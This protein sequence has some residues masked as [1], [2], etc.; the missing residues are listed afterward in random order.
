MTGADGFIGSHLVESLL[1]RGESVTAL[2]WYNSFGHIGWL[3]QIPR[4]LRSRL[5]IVAGDIRD[6][7]QLGTLVAGS[8][9]IIH[10]A[11][12]VGIPY[13][14]QAAD[15]YIQTNVTGTLN[16]LQAAQQTGAARVVIVSTSEVYGSAQQLPIAENHPRVGQSPYAASKIAAEE[17]AFSFYRSYHLP[18]TIVRPFNTYGPRQSSRA[19]IPT[20]I[21]QI[22]AGQT[23]LQLGS[24]TPQRD[25]LYV[26]ET[27]DGLIAAAQAD[28]SG[29]GQVIN[30]GTGTSYSVS[31]LVSI[32]SEIAGVQ[33][34]VSTDAT[35]VRPAASEVDHL[36]A[37]AT[38]AETLLGWKASIPL[39]DG[40][41][42]TIDWFRTSSTLTIRPRTDYQI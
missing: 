33:I 21:T 17:L 37:D 5:T 40:L 4:D 20:I 35:R 28:E 31:E 30:L 41:R 29:I 15:S 7:H 3:D 34:A 25:L 6:R 12:L 27:A 9:H 8:T 26:K 36:L 22:L 13:S 11:A 39:R 24:L 32:I 14:Y 2:V 42:A 38:K 1:A 16:L 19:I 18:V 23:Q 10:L